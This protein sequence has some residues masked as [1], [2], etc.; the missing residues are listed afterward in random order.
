[1]VMI[2]IVIVADLVFLGRFDHIDHRIKYDSVV[3][4]GRFEVRRKDYCVADISR[5]LLKENA[6]ADRSIYYVDDTNR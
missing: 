3:L 6:E 2:I 4:V 1:M 5:L